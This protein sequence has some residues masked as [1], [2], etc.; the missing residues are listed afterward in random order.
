MAGGCVD[1]WSTE[2]RRGKNRM[3]CANRGTGAP[4]RDLLGAVMAAEGLNAD[5][6][7][8]LDVV[9]LLTD[10]SSELIRGQVGTV[11]EALD[12]DSVLVEF[13]DD[14]GAA[15]AILPCRRSD[16]L[17]LRIVPLAA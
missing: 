17:T 8:V 9:A 4:F 1:H 3:D 10:L 15:Y 13:S 16:L 5:G 14:E 12:S 11:V 2:R 7:A 6:V